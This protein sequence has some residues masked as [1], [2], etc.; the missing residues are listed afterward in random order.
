[1]LAPTV[2]T[3]RL[4]LRAFRAEDFA[5]F[6]AMYANPEVVRHTGEPRSV[7]QSWSVFLLI[8]GHWHYLG[9]GAW[10]I[11][12]KS[13]GRHIGDVGF[14]ERRRDRG[15]DL[16]GVPE[17]G[18]AL[19][20]SSFGRGYATE[21]VQAALGWGRMHFGPRRVIAVIGTQNVASIRVAEKCGFREFQP[22]LATDPSDIFLDRVL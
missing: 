4:R 1:M 11:E 20:P 22:G 17:L 5:S 3:E 2:E 10:A 16:E 7:E 14:T 15:P 8:P 6:A 13:T 18:W 21:A 9:F 12:E 19:V